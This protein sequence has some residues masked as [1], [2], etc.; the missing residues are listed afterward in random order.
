MVSSSCGTDRG[1]FVGEKRKQGLADWAVTEG[2]DPHC[3]WTGKVIRRLK[4]LILGKRQ[5]N[6]V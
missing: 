5:S 1:W 3:L 6:F 4:W 2:Q